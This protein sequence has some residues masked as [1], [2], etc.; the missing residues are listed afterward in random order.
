[1]SRWAGVV[2]IAIAVVCAVAPLPPELVERWFSTGIYPRIQHIITPVSNQLPFAMF[3]LIVVAAVVAVVA[4]VVRGIA[5]ARTQRRVVPALAALGQI[6]VG[7]AV[8]YL[9]FLGLWGLNYRRV[10]MRDRLDVQPGQ[11]P[12]AAVLMLGNEAATSLNRLYAEAHATGWG[13][14]LWRDESLRRGFVEAQG[15]LS[16]AP[17]AVPGRLKST[18]FGSYFRWTNVD[19]MVDP[20]ALEVLANPDLLPWERPFV[21]AH[22]WSHLA[23]YADESDANFVGWIT[24]LHAGVPAQYSGWLYLFW[25]ISG[26]LNGR[27]RRQ[28]FDRLADGP[29]R[30]VNAIVARLRRG[31]IP[32]LQYTSWA[33][34]DSY[35]KANRVDEGIRSY[36]E[37]VTLILRARFANGWTPV[38][39]SSRSSR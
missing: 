9:V 37:V 15:F 17:P 35:L 27:D 34:Y 30:D 33:V 16:D 29:R 11:P 32:V 28:L 20:F 38:R 25:E 12:S 3:D 24:C 14:P 22:E 26:A 6:A 1:M 5:R 19:G 10:P 7:V 31:Q 36:G 13:E 2:V 4:A 39:R 21:A 18:I 8:V 23:G